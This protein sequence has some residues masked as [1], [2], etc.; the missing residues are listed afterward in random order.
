MQTR[1]RLELR[2]ARNRTEA[3]FG[4]SELTLD[5]MEALPYLNAVIVSFFDSV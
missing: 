5:E 1:L 4:R 3:E 2:E